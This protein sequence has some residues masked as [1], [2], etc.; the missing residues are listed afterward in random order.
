MN[1]YH[2]HPVV[3]FLGIIALAVALYLSYCWMP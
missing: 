3:D 2:P 1:D